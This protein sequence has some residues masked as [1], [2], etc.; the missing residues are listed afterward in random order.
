M[1]Q[2]TLEHQ[3]LYTGY[4]ILLMVKASDRLT[5]EKSC[6][7]MAA[8][9]LIAKINSSEHWTAGTRTRASETTE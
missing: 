8:N 9:W 5:M 1:E 3:T 4:K 2:P 6:I 7:E